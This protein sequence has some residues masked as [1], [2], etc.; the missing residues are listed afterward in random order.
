MILEL[1][2]TKSQALCFADDMTYTIAHEGL[3]YFGCRVVAREEDD[4]APE[5]QKVE[6]EYRRSN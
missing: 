5:K 6:F 1:L 2:L 3:T 4:R